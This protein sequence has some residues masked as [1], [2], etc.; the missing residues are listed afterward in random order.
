VSKVLTN[1]FNGQQVQQSEF[2]TQDEVKQI[3][4]K[5]RQ[6]SDNLERTCKYNWHL[7]LLTYVFWLKITLQLSTRRFPPDSLVNRIVSNINHFQALLTI[8]LH[9]LVL[10]TLLIGVLCYSFWYLHNVSSTRVEQSK[11]IKW[12]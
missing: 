10:Y 12:I 5:I 2:F 11:R 6:F 1:A 9:N 3:V 8:Y 7:Y 4:Q